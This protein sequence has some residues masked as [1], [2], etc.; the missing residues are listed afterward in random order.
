MLKEA[1]QK[2]EV[3]F[4]LS[5]VIPLLG[6]AVSWGIL[7]TKVDSMIDKGVRLRTE[8]EN[9]VTYAENRQEKI[10]TTLLQIQV[11][12]AEIQKDILY[13]KENLN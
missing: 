7:T 13:I 9:H 11:Q 4:W 5:I 12:L 8:F 3:S 10:D 2:P 1:I 6:F